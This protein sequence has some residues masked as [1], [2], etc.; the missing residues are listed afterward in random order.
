ML[1]LT[2]S[3]CLPYLVN[4]ISCCKPTKAPTISIDSNIDTPKIQCKKFPFLSSITVA[5]PNVAS[6]TP[7]LIII[8]PIM[9]F[10]LGF[11][12][13]MYQET[14]IEAGDAADL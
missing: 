3:G 10:V 13:F 11:R 14:N 6:R 12:F 2:S 8:A 1:Q 9:A 4:N 5:P 7:M